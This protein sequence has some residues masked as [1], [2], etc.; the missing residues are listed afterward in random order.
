MTA[1]EALQ[2]TRPFLLSMAPY[3]GVAV[4]SGA[5]A[6]FTFIKT[7]RFWHAFRPKLELVTALD[8]QRAQFA[9]VTLE[10]QRQARI[11]N[12]LGQSLDGVLK[13]LAEQ[14]L[15]IDEQSDEITELHRLR[16]A[17]VKRHQATVSY[18]VDL[19]SYVTTSA[20]KLAEL[21]VMPEWL[22]DDVAEGLRSRG[23]PPPNA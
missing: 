21:P 1:L 12:T 19:I 20:G 17:D 3:I 15:K 23:T 8:E 5:G 13:T 14:R 6:I 16:D 9:Q 11:A 22:H 7:R 18:I 2:V 10:I 4:A